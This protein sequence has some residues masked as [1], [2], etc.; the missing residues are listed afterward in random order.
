MMR[1]V[2]IVGVGQT[3]V[4]EHWDLGLRELGRSAV[5]D[6]LAD[7][8]IEAVDALYA[9][10]ML[11]G[12]INGQENVATLLADAAGLLPAEAWKVEAACASGAAAVRAA[13]MAV[14]SGAQEI[15]V[16]VGVEK[17]TDGSSAAVSAALATAADQDYEASHG[18]SFVSLSALLMR[19]YMHETEQPREAFAPFAMLAHQNAAANPRAMFR[20][21]ISA[22]AFATCA[23]VADPIGILDAA[24]VCDG[25]A[26]VVLCSKNTV[27]PHHKPVRISGSAV[28]SDTISLA[29]RPDILNLRSAGRSASRALAAAGCNLEDIDLFEAHDAFTIIT[30]LSLEACGFAKRSD[31]L[32]RAAEGQFSRTGLLPISTFG[33]LKA[34]GHPVGASG[35]YQIV[36]AVLQL[37]G[38]AGLNQVR[39]ARH[40]LTQ[41]IGG[42]GSIAV[43]HVLEA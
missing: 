4:G 19:R 23:L 26:A 39:P 10:N 14:A 18:L 16:A 17:M 40:A 37:R 28:A 34:R 29:A 42:H 6:A 30:V 41:S 27:R 11:G 15:A 12:A 20:E 21:P 2:F 3:P 43:A 32:K 24:P 36:E 33:G 31:V 5:E 35:A 38:E 8:R 13:A 9:G 25:A 1:D 22:E 7:A